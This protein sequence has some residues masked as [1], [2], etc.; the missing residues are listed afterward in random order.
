MPA[1]VLKRNFLD[2]LQEFF[3][4]SKSIGIVLFT[5]TILSLVIANLPFGVAYTN[6]FNH[7]SELLHAFHLPHSI[8][9][10]INDGFMAVF[11]FLVGMEIKREL[12]MGELSSIRQAIL[13]IG[14]AVG[15]MI[16]PA[17]IYL[18]FNKGTVYQGG[19]GI[20]MA[21][22][23]AFSLGVASMLGNRFPPALKIFL[24]AL[25]I[26]DDLGAILVIAFFYGGSVKGLWLLGGA[27]CIGLLWMLNFK[28][29][30]FGWKNIVLGLLLW[31][32]I[33]NSGVHAT[34]AGVLFAFMVPKNQLRQLEHSIHNTVNFIILPVFALANTAIIINASL[35]GSIGSTLG[36]GIAFG[37]FF[38]KPIGVVLASWLMVH[39]KIARLPKNTN[40]SQ[41]AGAGILAG[42]GFTMSIFI[43]SLAFDVQKM[44]E[45]SKI[46]V[47]ISAVLS[48]ITVF[49][50]MTF[51]SRDK[52]TPHKIYEETDYANL[53]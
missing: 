5:C 43:A 11:F 39:K 16:I 37:L 53:A 21:T 46:T 9:H 14:A 19:W 52:S 33:F 1:K 22:D 26:I 17:F 25:A 6:F 31:Y 4:D 49:I 24:M 29:Q 32:C 7:E 27:C 38:G 8:I 10:W 34:I 42:I 13:P 28:K 3:H 12:T 15:G 36:L 41:L 47:L 2:Y 44:Q 23:I 48:I 35:I 30:R 51:A 50:W 20:P 45:L 40:W 18:I